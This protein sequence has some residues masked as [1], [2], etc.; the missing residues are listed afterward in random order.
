VNEFYNKM[1]Y[2]EQTEGISAKIFYHYTSIEALYNI[3][4]SK[5]FRLTS[6]KTS[7]DKKELYYKPEMFLEDFKEI[8][9][10]EKD[11]NT[12]RYFSLI[13]E[14]IHQNTSQFLKECKH[15]TYPYALCLSEKKD[16]LTHWD[17]YAA[18]CTGVCIGFNIS[19]LCVLMQ[20]LVITAF[21]VGLYDV[22]KVLYTSEQKE[23]S[24]RN[25]LVNIANML[26]QAEEVDSNNIIDLVR[27][28]G[29]LYATSAYMQT[30]RFV[31]DDSFVDEDE[32]RLY[33]D[34][35]AIKSTIRL[36]DSLL[37][38]V[39]LELQANLKRHF[40]DFV[41]SLHIEEEKFYMSARGIRSY[42][43][44]C[45]AD[46]W[47]SGVIPEIILGPMCVQSRSELKRFL[48]ANGLEG[49]RVSISSVPIR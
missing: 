28:N 8:V 46:V 47:G 42:K 20:R 21:G 9:E 49:T 7:N 33:H 31:K 34:S 4:L 18:N 5:T 17:R 27:R 11:E 15:K 26:S 35:A 12:K 1:K 45:L 22:G 2:F 48:R 40:N 23:K 30:A 24:I 44:L 6:L 13:K 32:V 39:D 36:I 16:N 19:A 37:P 29:Y 41:A 10:K 14:S 43:E 3:V 25:S 38:D